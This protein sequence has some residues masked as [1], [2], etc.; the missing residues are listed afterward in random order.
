MTQIPGPVETLTRY[1]L[2]LTSDTYQYDPTFRDAVDAVSGNPVYDAAPEL[3]EALED[4]L[5]F[6]E[7]LASDLERWSKAIRADME[8]QKYLIAKAQP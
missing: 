7:E 4:S 6:N 5:S 1:C 3:L 2:Q 8:H